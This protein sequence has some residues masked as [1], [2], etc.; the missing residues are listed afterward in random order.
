MKQTPSQSLTVLHL[1][2]ETGERLP[3]LV[4]SHT[5]IPLRLATRWAV[6]YRRYRVQASTLAGNLHNIGRLYTW[7]WQI[8]GIDL[9]N[10]VTN[11]QWF[12]ARQLES[13]AAHL[14]QGSK[15]HSANVVMP[16]SYNQ[17]LA[18]AENF[19]CWCLYAHNRGGPSTFTFEQA[20]AERE[21]LGYLFQ[22]LRMRGTLS[23]RHEPLTDAEIEKIRGV[24]A[25]TQAS[26]GQW[27]FPTAGFSDQTALRNWLM[28]ELALEL[29][30]RRGELLKLRL[31]CLPRGREEGIK[32]LR[33]PDDPHDS[34]TLEPAVKTAE[35][36][37]PTSAQLLQGIRTYVTLPPPTGRVPGQSPYLFVTRRGQPISLD[38]AQDVIQIIGQRSHVCPLSWHRLRHTW[39]ERMATFLLQQPNG[40]DRLVY[41]GGWTH[42][43][44]PKRYIQQALAQQA[45]QT[46]RQYQAELYA[47][48]AQEAPDDD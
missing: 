32:V 38:T 30:L 23:Q 46:L 44:S 35:R 4:D 19:L 20:T 10:Y 37:L 15:T 18:V 16:N 31:D 36:I 26:N 14:R 12:D 40:L 41:L 45:G 47:H 2:L 42:A 13:L 9:D 6:R 25:P 24:I 7:A 48:T 28:F 27:L 39:A 22:S 34:R 11:G 21:K 3:C 1:V 33:Y 8:G 17:R 5:W 29:G 43:D